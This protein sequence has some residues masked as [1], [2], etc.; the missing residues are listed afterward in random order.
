[1]GLTLAQSYFGTPFTVYG[2]R[3]GQTP[4]FT[5]NSLSCHLVISYHNHQQQQNKNIN[6]I[7]VLCDQNSGA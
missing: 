3:T 5:E 4:C 2:K 7:L 1:M 6:T